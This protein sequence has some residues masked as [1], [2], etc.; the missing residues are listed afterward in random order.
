[1][2]F[3]IK[4]ADDHD[5]V[6]EANYSGTEEKAKP[7]QCVMPPSSAFSTP[8]HPSSVTSSLSIPPIPIQQLLPIPPP[9][10][11]PTVG[12]PLNLISSPLYKNYV[13][14]KKELYSHDSTV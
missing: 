3:Q 7:S 5:A 1:M 11:P 13:W 10:P 4:K 2:H 9:P 12:A 6:K 8:P 14:M